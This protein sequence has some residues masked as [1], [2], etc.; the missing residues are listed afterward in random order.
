MRVLLFGA[1]GAAGGSV[2]KVCLAAPGVDEVRAIVRRPLATS[3]T[4]LQQIQHTDFADYSPLRETFD[5][6]DTCLYCLGTSATQVAGEPAYR[7]I[8]RDFALAAARALKEESPQA[9]F[10]FVSGSGA[11]LNSRF[12][13]A[14]V[15]AETERDLMAEVGAVCWR[16]AFIDGETSSSSPALY[17]WIRP[18]GRLFAPFPS[19]YVSGADIGLAMLQATTE[20]LRGAIIENAELRAIARRAGPLITGP[21]A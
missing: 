1:T 8:T 2:L 9:P 18:L 7:R 10:H 3:H 17:Q 19:L 20:G 12:M 6:V 4:K 13:W 16:P 15:K 21:R 14:R 5:G 11:G